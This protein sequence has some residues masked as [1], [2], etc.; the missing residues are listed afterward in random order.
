MVGGCVMVGV[1]S[2]SAFALPGI[3]SAV[4]TTRIFND[5]P[6]S[7]LTFTDAYPA[8]V[9]INDADMSGGGFANLHN[10]SFSENNFTAAEFA[11]ADAFEF[12]ADMVISG[13][14]RAEAGL[15]ISPWWSPNVDGRLNVRSTDG[16]IAA[17]GGRLPFFSFTGA[18]GLTYTHGTPIHLGM[19]YS[20]NGLSMASPATIVYTVGYG[21]NTYSSGPLAFDEG[22]PGEDPPHGLWGILNPAYAGGYVQNFIQQGPQVQADWTNIHF[23]P[24]P[25]SLGL[26]AIGGLL[27]ARRRAVR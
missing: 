13:T 7:T 12:S 19:S 20:P 15:R 22:N 5:D 14:G 27:L 18:F 16:E 3:N 21:G 6:N 24:E 26:L 4:I 10:W 25:A 23:A 9:R 11:N 8:L 17:F 1:M 2:V